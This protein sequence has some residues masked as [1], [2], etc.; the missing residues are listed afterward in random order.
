MKTFLDKEPEPQN[1]LFRSGAKTV[2]PIQD[3]SLH[4][5]DVVQFLLSLVTSTGQRCSHHQLP[6]L[7]LRKL[8]NLGQSNS[9]FLHVMIRIILDNS[10]CIF[11]EIS[12]WMKQKKELSRWF[13]YEIPLSFSVRNHS[14][15]FPFQTASTD[16]C[17]A[18]P[19]QP[20][21]GWHNGSHGCSSPFRERLLSPGEW[22]AH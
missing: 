1:S 14:L 21:G 3:A 20:R 9:V 19:A 7:P 8:W 11:P 4:L 6:A 16:R 22:S 12:F 2:F 13:S 5:D 17:G 10:V 18:L 15:P